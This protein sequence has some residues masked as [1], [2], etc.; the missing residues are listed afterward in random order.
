MSRLS[1]TFV[2][3]NYGHENKLDPRAS[4]PIYKDQPE[5][6]FWKELSANV[7]YTFPKDFV[8]TKT[9]CG[10]RCET[11]GPSKYAETSYSFRRACQRGQRRI[12]LENGE[13]KHIQVH[14]P[15]DRLTKAIH[16]IRDPFDNVV[17]RFHMEIRGTGVD[18]TRERFREFCHGLNKRLEEEETHSLLFDEKWVNLTQDIPCRSDFFRW[19]EWHNQ[20]FSMTQD[21]N[22]ETMVVKYESYAKQFN[23]T[24]NS[25]LEFLNLPRRGSP[26]FFVA[27][28]GYHDYFT[29]TERETVGY[30]IQEM[31]S[32]ATWQYVSEYF[33]ALK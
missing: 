2:G 4:F 10:G 22:L 32:R 27:G 33:T 15:I 25:L 26:E 24:C 29:S 1:R 14:Y 18:S 9:H 6:P 23:Q 7:T 31:A 17:S 30:V 12:Q 19:I 16:L 13:M 5:G 20:A 28:K 11:C 3:T 8:M 21:L